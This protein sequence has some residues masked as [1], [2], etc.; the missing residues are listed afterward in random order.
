MRV[1]V[2]HFHGDS[3]FFEASVVAFKEEQDDPAELE[4]MMRSVLVEFEQYVKLNKKI[5]PEVVASLQQVEDAEKL[6][7]TIASHLSLKV[8]D[9]Q[10]LLELPSISKRLEQIY[11]CM[12]GEIGV[13]QVEKKIRNRV[14]RQMEK[15]Q[16]EYYLNEQL[17]A[18]QRE[19][20]DADDGG[21]DETAEL[22]DK[23]NKIKLTKEAKEKALAELKK[24]RHMSPMSAE[25]T[26]V[27]NYLD[28]LVGIP[29]KKRSKVKQDLNFAENILNSDHYGLEKVKERILEYLAVL[30]HLVLQ[31]V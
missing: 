11:S 28:W 20:G 21:R 24:L 3:D 15:T 9:K 26:V 10:A 23:I 6:S 8:S 22:E 2:M 27:R 5:P 19:L 1:R 12:E 25:A 17:K 4:A 13:M 18:I 7:D 31:S 14:K 29:W 30:K 16:R